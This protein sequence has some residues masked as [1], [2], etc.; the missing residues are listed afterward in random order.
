MITCKEASRLASQQLDRNLSFRE[1]L[2]LRLHL[3]YCAGCKRMEEQF[4]FLR[5][6][7]GAWIN[8]AD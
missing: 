1:R 4:R 6:A 2:Q 8:R 7:S 3:M 5:Q